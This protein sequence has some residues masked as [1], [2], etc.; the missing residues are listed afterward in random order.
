MMT[1]HAIGALLVSLA[2]AEN[3][4]FQISIPASLRK[5][6]GYS[7]AR[8]PQTILRLDDA[9]PPT[10]A[11]SVNVPMTRR[12][13]CEA[14]SI[15]TVAAATTAR[16]ARL[17]HDEDLPHAVHF[18]GRSGR[19]HLVTKARNAQQ[20]G[21]TALVV[22]DNLCVCGSACSP[23][24]GCQYTEPVLADD[25]SGADIVIPAVMLPKQEADDIVNYF[26][27]GKLPIQGR[28]QTCAWSPDWSQEA[29]VQASLEY[30]VPNPG[31]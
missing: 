4:V 9:A 26:R 19:L 14:T 8:R 1:R 17:R 30:T 13:S 5:P 16:S 27:C 22:A 20:M 23:Q 21:A 24:A 25:G 29:M 6:G 2:A 18:D 12:K 7:H 3:S 28:P 31:R 10:P 15:A 11:R